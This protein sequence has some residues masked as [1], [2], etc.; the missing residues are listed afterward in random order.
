MRRLF[1]LFVSAFFALGLLAPP[2][3]LAQQEAVDDTT[4]YQMLL[5]AKNLTEEKDYQGTDKCRKCHLPGLDKVDIANGVGSRV[6]RKEF[7][8]WQDAD[9]HS[10]A[11][12]ALSNA[13][14]QMI[15]ERLHA[16]VLEPQ[17]GCVQCHTTA[18]SS[19]KLYVEGVGC[20]TCHGPSSKWKDFHDTYSQWHDDKLYTLTKK[21]D[22]GWI[23]IR[24]PLTRAELCLSCHIGNIQLNRRITHDM[25]AAGHPFLAGFELE[26]FADKMPRHWR[27]ANERTPASNKDSATDKYERTRKMLV[28]AIVSLRV[29]AELAVADAAPDSGRWPELARFECSSCH[30]DLRETG[31]RTINVGAP[32]RPSI[33][34]PLVYVAAA[35]ANNK[36]ADDLGRC[37]KAVNDAKASSPFGNQSAIGEKSADLVKWCQRAEKLVASKDFVVNSA[38]ATRFLHQL[39]AMAAADNFD[40]DTARELLAAWLVCFRE[41]KRDPKSGLSPTQIREIESRLHSKEIDWEKFAEAKPETADGMQGAPDDIKKLSKEKFDTI[42]TQHFE[43][44]SRFEPAKYKALMQSL[45][46]LVSP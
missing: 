22:L 2:I 11:Y 35:M 3:L 7:K 28:A 4:E 13:R 6:L 20:E 36:N 8:Y 45:S 17:A 12:K 41:M 26:T 29:S 43:D 34:M 14:G 18:V 25:Y 32:G 33:M 31:A 9:H 39:G 27:Y 37:I 24:S 46:S 15:G 44:R 21:T 23:N 42:L 1:Y 10:D 19:P 40:Y 16:K 30:H 38:K 5:A